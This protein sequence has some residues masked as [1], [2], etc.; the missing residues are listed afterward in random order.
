MVETASY[1]VRPSQLAPLLVGLLAVAEVAEDE[2]TNG[3][4]W[5]GEK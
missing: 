5:V 3:Q 2:R 4:W 1:K